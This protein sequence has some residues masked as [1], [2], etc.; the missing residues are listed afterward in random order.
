MLRNKTLSGILKVS[1]SNLCIVLSGV[2]VGFIIPKILGVTEYGYYKIFTLYSVY[3]G[4]FSMGISEGIYL[5]Y[6]GIPYKDIDKDKIRTFTRI[7]AILEFIFMLLI[8]FLALVL[9]QGQYRVIF[10]A[11]AIY[12]FTLNMTTYYQYI[13]QMTLRFT[14]YSMR[15]MIRSAFNVI[16]T[17]ILVGLYY[18]NDKKFISYKY[19]LFS[20]IFI[21]IILLLMYIK[22]FSEISF[23]TKSNFFKYKNELVE[24][25]KLGIPFLVASVCSTLILTID[26]QFISILFDMRT[27]GIYAFAY[28]LLSLV[29]V[30]T[31]AI[32]TVLY[33]TL[34]QT[35][36]AELTNKYPIL[37]SYVLWFVY[38]SLFVYFPLC[39]FIKE[40]LP[41][42][43]GSLVFFR[44]VFP[45][46]A[47]S[48]VISV[49]IQNYYKLINKNDLF[50]YENL[51]VL[52]IS[53]IINSISYFI[54]RTP[55]SVSFASV[56]TLIIYYILS[57]I[58]FVKFYH[59]KWSK[60]FVYALFMMFVFYSVTEIP[61]I[62][63]GGIIYMVV[64]MGTLLIVYHR[65]V[66]NLFIF[67]KSKK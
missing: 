5:K 41:Q 49:V 21:S 56:L 36:K 23:G 58:Y 2:F 30:F 39:F 20:V 61:N 65:P 62:Y 8:A 38:L 35:K 15:N 45:G 22:K 32:S 7:V 26:S 64:F 4:I 29:T 46:L 34:K 44:I 3:I 50:F 19:Y 55:E 17:L 10:I 42:Y 66:K 48:S 28:N 1:F 43:I 63:I 47:F 14:D 33:P 25:M 27:Y 6:S 18:F 54:F 12:L 53:F 67:I 40:F 11:L 57:E 24:L 31:S 13:A 52:I 51:A 59:I 37:V 9:F 60:N 16:S